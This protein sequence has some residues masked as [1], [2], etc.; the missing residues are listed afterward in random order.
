VQNIIVALHDREAIGDALDKAAQLEHYTG[1]AVTVV[2]TCWD[3]VSEEPTQH[4]PQEEIDSI[5]SRMKAAELNNLSAAVVHYR[6]HIADLRAEVL[7]SKHHA[8]AVA[9]FAQER[10]ADLIVAPRHPLG[11]LEGVAERVLLPEEIKLAARAQTPL[12]LTSGARWG[13]TANVL[14]ALDVAGTGHDRLNEQLVKLGQSLASSLGGELHMLSVA[15]PPGTSVSPMENLADF[16]KAS[17]AHRR[18]RLDDIAEMHPFAYAGLHV[19]T[20]AV[21]EAV[22]EFASAYDI[23]ICLVGTAARTG[24]QRLFIGN[25]AESILNQIT[26]KDILMVPDPEFS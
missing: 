4:F 14:V 9:R 15:P 6:E 3:V 2:Q 5:A 11:L 20:G 8:D 22:D 12:L 7:W 13:Q 25:T 18:T 16:Q 24:L 1:A 10:S 21:S 17:E 26:H 23:D 19:H